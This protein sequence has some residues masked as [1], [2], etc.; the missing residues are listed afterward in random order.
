[1]NSNTSEPFVIT[2]SPAAQPKPARKKK[3]TVPQP[4]SDASTIARRIAKGLDTTK[5]KVTI[6]HA[7]SA[8]LRGAAKELLATEG[9]YQSLLAER[10]TNLSSALKKA[11]AEGRIFIKG[12][13]KVLSFH[14]GDRCNQGWAESGFLNDTLQ[15][16]STLEKREGLLQSLARFLAA[17]PEM[18]SAPQNIT[19]E[20]AK[21]VHAALADAQEALDAADTLRKERR[22]A[23][24]KA[25]KRLRKMLSGVIH[26]IRLSL[27]ADSPLWESFGLT[28]PK[29]RPR[30][31]KKERTMATNAT[32]AAETGL[33]M[34]A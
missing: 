3:L 33:T 9:D 18:E 7:T 26:E 11:D 34:A 12:A 4:V 22:A 25:D 5:G 20:Q 32:P 8:E 23:R 24:D 6:K 29:P 16:P 21:A 30:R 15:M 13:K 28:A 19:A 17:L 1:M 14:L 10:S 2:S 27:T 31:A